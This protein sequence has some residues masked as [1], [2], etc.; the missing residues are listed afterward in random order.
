[1]NPLLLAVDDYLTMRRGLGFKIEGVG[2]ALRSFVAFTEREGAEFIT[3]KLALRWATMPTQAQPHRWAVRLGIVRRFARHHHA[4][5]PRTE[6]PPDGI[7]PHSYLRRAPH[8]Y[9]DEDV[10]KL[11]AAAKALP[12]SHGLRGRTYA[13]LL[14]L[15]SA[16]GLRLGEALGLDRD[17]VDIRTGVLTIR[18]AKFGKTRYVPMHRTTCAALGRYARIRDRIFPGLRTPACFVSERCVRVTRGT[19]EQTFRL[20]LHKVGLRGL[21]DRSGPHIHDFRHGFAVRTLL[22]WYRAGLDVERRMA[23]LAT[24]LGHVEV[25]DTY[26][27]ISAT[28]ELLRWAARRLDTPLSGGGQ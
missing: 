22:S 2:F 28:P 17:D 16:A 15:L 10:Q 3:I 4:T 19:A 27:Y 23:H 1:M 26:W 21:S 20:L 18:H 7:L 8:I 25:R 9:S 6:I 13:T 5:D 24:Y 14:G 12:S 11:L